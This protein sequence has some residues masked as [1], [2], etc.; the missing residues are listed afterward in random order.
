[1]RRFDPEEIERYL[2]VGESLDKAAAYSIQGE[3]SRL[4]ETIRG[5]YL[6][7]VGLPLRPIARYL[8]SRGMKPARHLETLYLDRPFPNWRSF[9]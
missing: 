1:M 7:A 9:G 5:D 6:A 4:I 2:R 3:G 8:E